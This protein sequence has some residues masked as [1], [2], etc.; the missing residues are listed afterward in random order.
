MI[1]NTFKHGY[2]NSKI[3]DSDDSISVLSFRL[4]FYISYNI[5]PSLIGYG[6]IDDC[7]ISDPFSV[8]VPEITGTDINQVYANVPEIDR[9]INN[10]LRNNI[11]NSIKVF[12][13][14]R[15]I[16]IN[17]SLAVF[18]LPMGTYIDFDYRIK[19]ANVLRLIKSTENLPVIGIDDIRSRISEILKNHCIMNGD[20][21]L[22]LS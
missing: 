7:K 2:I 19:N 5:I 18:I 21:L 1:G 8:W 9:S 6:I 3:N 20:F 4:P 13:D 15:D 12:S 10:Y 22:S 11:S 17:P 16:L 14:L